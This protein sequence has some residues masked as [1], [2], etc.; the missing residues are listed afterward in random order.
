MVPCK[1]PRIRR[2]TSPYDCYS[3]KPKAKKCTKSKSGKPRVFIKS[4]NKCMFPC[5]KG[6]RRHRQS[7]FSC[8]IPRKR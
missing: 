3:P 4:A 5:S 6:M 7:P 8:Y 2:S 1:K